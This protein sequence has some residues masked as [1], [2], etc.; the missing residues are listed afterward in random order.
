MVIFR[1]KGERRGKAMKV[2]KGKTNKQV[3]KQNK[4]RKQTTVSMI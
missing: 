2:K 4:K 1:M 3:K